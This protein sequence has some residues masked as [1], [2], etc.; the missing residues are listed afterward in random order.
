M[1]LVIV[2]LIVVLSFQIISLYDRRNSYL[3]TEAEKKE[4]LLKAEKES[5]DLLLYEEY[6]KTPE[7]IEATAKKKLGMLK[8]NEI[9]FRE[10]QD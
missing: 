8:Q 1:A 5:E 10:K 6:T 7:Y 9:V 3:E 2:F 4:E